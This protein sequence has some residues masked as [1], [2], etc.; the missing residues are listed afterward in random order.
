MIHIHESLRIKTGKDILKEYGEN[1]TKIP[2][3]K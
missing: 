3:N 1:Y 2:A